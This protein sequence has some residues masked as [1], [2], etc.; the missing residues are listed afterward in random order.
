MVSGVWRGC[1]VFWKLVNPLL[2]QLPQHWALFS[3]RVT[4]CSLLLCFFK[5]G[6]AHSVGQL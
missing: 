6:L 3:V 1:A 4:A 5:V 2:L